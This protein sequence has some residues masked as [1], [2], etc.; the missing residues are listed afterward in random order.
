MEQVKQEIW[1]TLGNHVVIQELK[2]NKLKIET[3]QGFS[4]GKLRPILH[5]NELRLDI[6]PK[7]IIIRTQ[8]H[9]FTK[10]N[11]TDSN[12]MSVN[13]RQEEETTEN[14]GLTKTYY[15]PS[16]SWETL[17]MLFSHPSTLQ[18][19]VRCHDIGKEPLISITKSASSNTIM[20]GIIDRKRK[21]KPQKKL[22]TINKSKFIRKKLEKRKHWHRLLGF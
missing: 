14:I 22:G 8:D 4:Y 5:D 19:Y 10:P 1:K 2:G 13:C 15:S 17:E 11:E 6:A 12:N 16:I 7:N 18:L 9:D 20:G 3:F 21:N